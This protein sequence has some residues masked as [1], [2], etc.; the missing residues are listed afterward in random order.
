M[1]IAFQIIIFVMFVFSS[2]FLSASVIVRSVCSDYCLLFELVD[3]DKNA[4][5]WVSGAICTQIHTHSFIHQRKKT[6]DRIDKE[7]RCIVVT[8]TTYSIFSSQFGNF[9]KCMCVF[10]SYFNSLKYH[11]RH[12]HFVYGCR[13]KVVQL[14]AD[15]HLKWLYIGNKYVSLPF[16]VDDCVQMTPDFSNHLDSIVFWSVGHK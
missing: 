6:L 7:F 12:N 3:I 2:F 14:P 13:A 9:L 10:F 5:E 16:V 1:T 4:L 11:L 15:N 8:N